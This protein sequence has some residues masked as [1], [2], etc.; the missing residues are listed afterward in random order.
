MLVVLVLPVQAGGTQG[1]LVYDSWDAAYLEG[2]R[3]GY[4]H[5][6]VEKQ[7]D[8]DEPSYRTTMKM[9]LKVKR[10]NTLIELRMDTGTEETAEG[11]VTGVFMRQYL[12]QAKQL[13][14]TGKVVGKQVKLMLDGTKP[15]KPAPWND[16]VVGLYRQQTMFRDKMV[17]PGDTFQFLSFEPSIN[18]VVETTVKVKDSEDVELF[19]GQK[20][21]RLLR[22]ETTPEKVENV[23]LP[24]MVT[25]LNEQLEPVRSETQ[26]P[27]LGTLTL[28]RTTKEGALSSGAGAASIDVGLNQLVPLKQ[29][30]ADPYNVREA[31]YRITIKGDDDP[32]SALARDDRQT[33]KKVQ[34]STLEVQ[35]RGDV[36]TATAEKAGEEF[37]QSSYFINSQDAQVQRIARTAVGSETDPW[38]KALRLEKWVNKNMRGRSHE[39]LATADHV[40]RTLEGDCT[41]FA[42]LLAAL[43]RA[44]DIPAKTAIG[45]IYAN[46]NGRPA[47]SFHMWTEVWISGRWVP[48][49]ATLGRG[50]VGA[51][52][53][54]VTDHSWHETRSLLPLLPV[55]RVLGRMSIEVVRTVPGQGR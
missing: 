19:G 24:T 16:A 18:L 26:I 23:Q 4:V 45:L 13:D 7:S 21:Q 51:T 42:M 27:G 31:L 37:L 54:K 11:K 44:Q 20:K 50:H 9:Q 33:I 30:I 49:D 53:L 32:A 25:W 22:V 28:Y 5:T 46:V 15:L 41:E 12:G 1:K 47:F 34:G 55:V 3:A 14:L 36:A 40:A 10:F 6:S 38:K 48:L 43:C 17:K 8:G 29:F 35:V 39:Q 2:K 52:H